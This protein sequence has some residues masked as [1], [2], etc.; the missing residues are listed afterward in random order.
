MFFLIIC[1][2]ASTN[3][4]P[5]LNQKL[6]TTAWSPKGS[7]LTGTLTDILSTRPFFSTTHP[8]AFGFLVRFG[9][10]VNVRMMASLSKDAALCH[11][12]PSIMMPLSH[13]PMKRGL[14]MSIMSFASM[15][16]EACPSVVLLTII[17]SQFGS[18]FFRT[19]S[20]PYLSMCSCLH[21]NTQ[22]SEGGMLLIAFTIMGVP[23][24]SISGFG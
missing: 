18:S 6:P 21:T 16:V 15:H 1:S 17:I 4:L 20:I 10:F 3:V 2:V 5:D 22:S 19:S 7:S 11:L 9:C 14:S 24:T 13:A 12:L 23:E 8:Y